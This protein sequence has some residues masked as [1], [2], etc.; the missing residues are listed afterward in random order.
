MNNSIT[1][2]QALSVAQDFA[3]K[4]FDQTITTDEM[5]ELT[6]LLGGKSVEEV[7]LVREPQT[8]GTLTQQWTYRSLA[9]TQMGVDL[10]EALVA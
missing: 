2:E 8:T 7:I 4:L 9:I 3:I 10:S 1:E 5:T 6:S